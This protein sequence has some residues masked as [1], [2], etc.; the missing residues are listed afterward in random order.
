[1]FCLTMVGRQ[2]KS[3]EVPTS[4]VNTEQWCTGLT[5]VRIFNISCWFVISFKSSSS[6][7]QIC[8][9]P[10]RMQTLS[11]YPYFY[12]QA[13]SKLL[14]RSSLVKTR[15]SNGSTIVIEV[16]LSLK[17]ST[18]VS[19]KCLINC[20]FAYILN[21]YVYICSQYDVYGRVWDCVDDT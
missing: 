19:V 7:V 18:W 16:L 5:S 20:I 3:F 8:H 10:M 2:K 13:V 9:S 4:V 6:A 11:P 14:Q 15:L 17:N 21:I 12:S 1:M